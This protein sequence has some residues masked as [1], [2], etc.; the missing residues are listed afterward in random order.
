MRVAITGSKGLVGASIVREL[1]GSFDIAEIDLP[2]TDASDFAQ[3]QRA[4]QG[5]DALIHLAWK[6]LIPNV[7][8]NRRDPLNMSMV[9]N[10]Y[11]ACVA[12][13]IRRVIMGS[14]NQAH[15]YA[16]RDADGRIRVG[17]DDQPKNEYGREKLEMEA[18][19]RRFASNQGLEVI[20][21][22]IGN[23][24]VE[25]QPKPTVDGRPQRWLSQQDLGRL[26]TSA[27]ITETVPDNFQIIYGVSDGPVYDW[28]NLIGYTPLD[29]AE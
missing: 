29:H 3:L 13:G 22:R 26:V 4:T 17:L 20:C 25:D 15:G 9:K 16:I 2:E 5:A 6:D 7:T 8:A 11:E 27:L 21:L 19:G 10:A 14:S 23:V 28:S 18:M 12:N 1:G 24:N